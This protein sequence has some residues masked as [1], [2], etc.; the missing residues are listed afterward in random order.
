VYYQQDVTTEWFE[1]YDGERYLE[2]HV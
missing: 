2:S 1:N